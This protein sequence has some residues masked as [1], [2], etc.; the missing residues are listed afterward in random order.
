MKMISWIIIYF[1]LF[2]GKVYA[3]MSNQEFF[4]VPITTDSGETITIGQ[5]KG[6]KP[7]YLKFWASWCQPCRKQMPHFE[8]VQKKYGKQMQVI[9]VNLGVNDS[10]KAI[11][12]T[13]N[14]FGLTM[15][16]V[17]DSNGQMAQ[18]FNLIGTPYHIL[19][20][21]QG[22][23]VHTGHEASK[24]LDTK[25]QAVTAIK[26]TN[27]PSVAVSSTSGSYEKLPSILK[28]NSNKDTVL[29]FVATWCDW[30]LKDPRPA[31]SQQC[32]RA[33]HSINS[34]YKKYPQYNWIGIASRLWTGDKEL[35][36]YKEKYNI[37]HTLV[38]DTSNETFLQY[39]VK[40]FPTLLFIKNGKELYRLSEF[41][42]QIELPN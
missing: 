12:N 13:K 27:L 19:I 41:N 3:S 6:N 4:T 25:I 26:S 10:L 5:Y 22:N 16:M 2:Y 40:N 11:E 34:L 18:A 36:E 35:A 39:G 15:P 14:E 38:I 28:E 24:E 9:A 23:I 32:I 37:E 1:F 29:F 42:D 31:M 21:I 17:I 30:Y 33:Q 7:V 8:Q 20:D